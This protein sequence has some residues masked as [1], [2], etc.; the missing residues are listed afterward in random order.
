KASAR[1]GSFV[2][3][4]ND[5]TADIKLL[6]LFNV[7]ADRWFRTDVDPD[8]IEAGVSKAAAL[9]QFAAEHGVT[10][11]FA[12]NSVDSPLG[13]NRTGFGNGSGHLG[14]IFTQLACLSRE[15]RVSFGRFLS[16]ESGNGLTDCG[17]LVMTAFWDDEVAEGVE[18]L[19]Q[20]GNLVEIM[21]MERTPGTFGSEKEA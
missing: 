6:I 17:I 10:A 14:E 3:N 7:Q 16:E 19:R 15:S 20:D 11:A 21:M 5:A 2:V 1:T 12:S 18:K 8:C 4:E 13:E 9:L